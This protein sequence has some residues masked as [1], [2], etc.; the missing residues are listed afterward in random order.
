[1]MLTN[2]RLSEKA[3]FINGQPLTKMAD[4][5]YGNERQ[6]RNS[7]LMDALCDFLL[8]ENYSDKG[9]YYTQMNCLLIK[10][11]I[12]GHLCLAHL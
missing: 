8:Y 5:L 1:M 7:E 9:A 12:D 6:R 10:L 4:G 3:L 11:N 2:K